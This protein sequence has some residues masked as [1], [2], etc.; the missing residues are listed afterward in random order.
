V[1]EIR[2]IPVE[3]SFGVRQGRGTPLLEELRGRDTAVT[4]IEELN[5]DSS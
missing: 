5:N 2:D 4:V 3:I 1:D